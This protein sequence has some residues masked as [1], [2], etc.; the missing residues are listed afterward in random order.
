[1]FCN[2]KGD[3]DDSKGDVL[4]TENLSQKLISDVHDVVVQR[5]I[6]DWM[7]FGMI[8]TLFASNLHKIDTNCDYR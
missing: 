6:S 8:L 5:W 3:S 7:C 1:M 2:L 4:R